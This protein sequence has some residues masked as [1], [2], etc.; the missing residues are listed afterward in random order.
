MF[1]NLLDAGPD[2]AMCWR[3]RGQAGE[4]SGWT[5]QMSRAAP[6]G[7]GWL[8]A[9]ASNSRVGVSWLA[10][11][12]I[13]PRSTFRFQSYRLSACLGLY[14]DLNQNIG[15]NKGFVQEDLEI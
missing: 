10:G 6:R 13:H 8:C 2:F 5:S 15:R 1:K 12:V 7:G 14:E 4:R 11:L 3:E 9:T